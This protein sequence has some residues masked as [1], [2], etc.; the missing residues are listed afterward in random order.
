[1]RM[2]KNTYQKSQREKN[3]EKSIQKQD[4]VQTTANKLFTLALYTQLGKKDFTEK[5]DARSVEKN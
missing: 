1:M 3:K 5:T 4:A 2:M